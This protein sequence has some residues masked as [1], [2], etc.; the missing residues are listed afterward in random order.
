M[1]G[2]AESAVSICSSGFQKVY[3][4]E[5]CAFKEERSKGKVE[6]DV[7]S[8]GREFQMDGAANENE[9]RPFADRISGT[10]SR[11]L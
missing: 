5:R 3:G 1:G 6:Q 7:S 9:R 4:G 10:V 8:R 2:L 11:S